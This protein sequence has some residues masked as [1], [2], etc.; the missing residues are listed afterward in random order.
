MF[1]V[2]YDSV[3]FSGGDGREG[4]SRMSIS[5]FGSRWMVSEFAVVLF[6]NSSMFS[7]SK[8]SLC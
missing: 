7:L 1:Q 4:G 3:K 8:S 6:V 5:E 2:V